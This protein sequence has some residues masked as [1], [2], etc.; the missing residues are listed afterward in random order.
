MS[1]AGRA[2]VDADIDILRFFG[3]L[4]RDKFKILL[5]SAA[6]AVAVGLLLSMAA[7][8]YRADSRVLIEPSE[9][10]FTRPQDDTGVAVEVVDP[11][12]VASQVEIITST[13]LL[14]QVAQDLNLAQYSEF[15]ETK[16]MGTL[17]GMAIAFGLLGDPGRIPVEKR[18]LEAMRER[19]EVFPVEQSR[20]IIIQF[21]SQSA[22][23]AA[24]VPNALAEAYVTLE[25]NASLQNTGEAS[26]FLAGEIEQLQQSVRVAEG[27]VADYR[28]ANELFVGQ[29]DEVLATQQLSELST[30]LSRVRADRSSLDARVG[31]IEGALSAGAALDTL[32]DVIASPLVAR[33]T[34]QRAL[35]NA[36]AAELSTTLL[37]NHPRLRAV[38]A[39]LS[40][41]DS[42]IRSQAQKV[43][44]GLRNEADI[45]R[46]R[47]AELA[48]DLNTLKAASARAN[49]QAIEL[50][51]LEREAASQR[52]LLETYLVRF[53]EAQ[54]R[55]E[56]QYAPAPARVISGA[57]VPFEVHFPKPLPIVIG[58]FIGTMVLMSLYTLMAELLSGRAMVAAP[59]VPVR[60]APASSMREKSA[61]PIATA[62]SMETPMSAIDFNNEDYS[63]DRVG[64]TILAR[65]ASRILVVS[66]ESVEASANAVALTRQLS[67]QGLRAVIVDV[68]GTNAAGQIMSAEPNLVGLTDLLVA[69]ASYGDAIHKDDVSDAHFIPAGQADP[70][71]A[72]RAINRLTIIADALADAYDCVII[73]CGSADLGSMEN[74]MSDTT[75]IVI[76]VVGEPRLQTRK[77]VDEMI[78]NGVDDL[79]LIIGQ[80]PDLP[81]NPTRNRARAQALA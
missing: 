60:P 11:E 64:Q 25:S 76:S 71:E 35:L 44:A 73:D 8:T 49:T 81:V 52:E 20:V 15:D 36:Q 23:L 12:A 59:S 54:S 42:Q 27:R 3:A 22:E 2:S 10:I 39:Q 50:N 58:T 45:A 77:T 74:L 19:L 41:I 7:P 33:L 53:R 67:E 30:E 47:E 21:T 62:P 16:G 28:A 17:K 80:A 57:T 55:D 70:Y 61:E 38:R 37:P 79:L 18:V 31:S 29:N 46:A 6:V 63:V 51:A 32:P 24:M 4:W 34:D 69:S 14:T 65:G 40:E 1:D 26:R 66:P 68:T 13:D 43:L 9:T 56:G 78:S 75:Q 48:G 5:V 72:A